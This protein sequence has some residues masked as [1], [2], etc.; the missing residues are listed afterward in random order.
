MSTLYSKRECSL[1]RGREKG[2]VDIGGTVYTV[3]TKVYCNYEYTSGHHQLNSEEKNNTTSPLFKTHWQYLGNRWDSFKAAHQGGA[4]IGLQ[5]GT[6]LQDKGRV[7]VLRNDRHCKIDI[8]LQC[9]FSL[10]TSL[11]F[12][13]PE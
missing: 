7:E 8:C 12:F 10:I 2:K 6:C 9:F 4:S 3:Y 11:C 1:Y 5:A 13:L